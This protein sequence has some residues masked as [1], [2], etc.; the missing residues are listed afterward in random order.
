M[1]P[2]SICLAEGSYYSSD[3]DSGNS[4]G[5]ILNFRVIVI[6]IME[7][8][9]MVKCICNPSYSGGRDQ[10]DRKLE[11]SPGK[12]FFEIPSQPTRAC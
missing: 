4:T 3:F 11:A 6:K 5:K 10:E 1:K 2:E 7:P 9:G 12:M 8:L